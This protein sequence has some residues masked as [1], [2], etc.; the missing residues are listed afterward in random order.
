M[1]GR[2]IW[3]TNPSPSL[4][5]LATGPFLNNMYFDRHVIWQ[6]GL[7]R[8]VVRKQLLISKK[9]EGTKRY[10][11]QHKV[12]PTQLA[13]ANAE[14]L[15]NWQVS[16][17]SCPKG[18]ITEHQ[19]F[20]WVVHPTRVTTKAHTAQH[21]IVQFQLPD[22]PALHDSCMERCGWGKAEG[23]ICHLRKVQVPGL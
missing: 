12:I 20:W 18:L 2:V 6:A 9:K 19:C 1:Y 7:T 5:E 17:N 14:V 4:R 8:R 10:Y 21:I 13:S 22:S 15:A 11:I 16:E 3:Y 23:I